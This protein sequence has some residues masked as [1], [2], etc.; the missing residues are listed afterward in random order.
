MVRD[1]FRR[2]GKP[3]GLIEVPL[4]MAETGSKISASDILEGKYSESGKKPTVRINVGS[5]NPVKVEAVR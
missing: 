1:R 4:V 5:A 2:R 3:L